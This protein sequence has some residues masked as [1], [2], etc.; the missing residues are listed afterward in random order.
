MAKKRFSSNNHGESISS[1][2]TTGR[3]LFDQLRSFR[4]YNVMDLQRRPFC[5]IQSEGQARGRAARSRNSCP[6]KS[7][8]QCRSFCLCAPRSKIVSTVCFYVVGSELDL[9]AIALSGG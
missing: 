1:G 9:L 6:G 4:H 7:V 3:S 8:S 2:E 5:P